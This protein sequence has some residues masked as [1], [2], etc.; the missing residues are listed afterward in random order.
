MLSTASSSYRVRSNS[1]WMAALRSSISKLPMW[2]EGSSS[3]GDDAAALP[4]SRNRGAAAEDE[5]AAATPR[6]RAAAR[7][8]AAPSSPSRKMRDSSP[9]CTGVTAS[10]TSA[11]R[12]RTMRAGA[13]QQ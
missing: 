7:A 13:V 12:W 4:Q 1:G 11:R 2:P 5:G 9:M 10:D 8:V 6:E 3:G